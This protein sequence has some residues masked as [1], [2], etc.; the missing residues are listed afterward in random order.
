MKKYLFILFFLVFFIPKR[1]WAS[2]T[3]VF[4]TTV[5]NWHQYVENRQN[6]DYATFYRG[7]YTTDNSLLV[8]YSVYLMCPNQSEQLL[9]DSSFN[10]GNYC[11][12]DGDVV[13][14]E[15]FVV[16]VDND[17]SA[18]IGTH[19][20]SITPSVVAFDNVPYDISPST[21]LQNFVYG[22]Y[23]RVNSINGSAIV[24]N[25]LDSNN[26][27]TG[28]HLL[29]SATLYDSNDNKVTDFDF[30]TV[31]IPSYCV[32]YTTYIKGNLAETGGSFHFYYNS[33]VLFSFSADTPVFN[34][35]FDG[36]YVVLD[37]LEAAY[38]Q[39]FEVTYGTGNPASSN[40]TV[41]V[42]EDSNAGTFEDAL[43]INGNKVCLNMSVEA[44]SEVDS[45]NTGLSYLLKPFIIILCIISITFITWIIISKIRGK[46]KDKEEII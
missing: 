5:E 7:S 38:N 30:G 46:K 40:Y 20:F 24:V 26:V 18:T 23:D 22:D 29:H 44:F 21:T 35:Y 42:T 43:D 45:S 14:R 8:N 10:F 36:D 1:V 41:T 32:N 16:D 19:T 12:G 37:M 27:I 15:E 33:D 25:E 34:Y 6:V 31:H 11:S 39:E 4:T 28:R 2:E 9:D 3:F 13:I 17:S